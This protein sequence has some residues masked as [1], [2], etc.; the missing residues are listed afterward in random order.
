MAEQ[1]VPNFGRAADLDFTLSE[2]L[3]ELEKSENIEGWTS[4]ELVKFC[5]HSR[6]WVSEKLLQTGL[7]VAAG[8]R[9]TINVSGAVTWKTVYAPKKIKLKED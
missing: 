5:K 3:Q 1:V 9:R 8:K 7:L 6:E 4:R 2:L